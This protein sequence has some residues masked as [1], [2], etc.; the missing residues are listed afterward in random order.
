[1]QCRLQHPAPV[2]TSHH[3]LGTENNAVCAVADIWHD[4][5][6]VQKSF[7]KIAFGTATQDER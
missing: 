6:D 1:M 3:T 2:I 7:Q 4:T 5:E